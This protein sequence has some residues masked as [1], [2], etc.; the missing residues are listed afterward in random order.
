MYRVLKRVCIGLVMLFATLLLI[1][2]LLPATAHVERSLRI[3]KS[4]AEVYAIVSD[5]NHS[6]HWDPWASTDPTI[7]TKVTGSGVGSTYEWTGDEAGRGISK[8]IVAEA[9]KHVKVD[10]RMFEPMDDQFTA[11]WQ[12]EAVDDATIA[13]WSYDQQLS[14][15]ARYI[16][17]CMDAILGESFEQ[18]LA[19]L[20]KYVESR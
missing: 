11:Q 7:V 19:N 8:M 5:F 1:P 12:L 2:A 16:G 10:I 13:T 18:G 15:S 6:P 4:P 3:E 9:P 20:K 17:I 14:Y